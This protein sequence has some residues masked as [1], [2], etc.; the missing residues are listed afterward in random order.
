MR[1]PTATLP[2]LPKSR[3]KEAHLRTFAP[4]WRHARNRISVKRVRDRGQGNRTLPRLCSPTGVQVPPS[5]S[6]ATGAVPSTTPRS[7]QIRIRL[8]ERN[9]STEFLHRG[10]QYPA[11]PAGQLHLGTG[12]GRG[13]DRPARGT[14]VGRG[15][16]ESS[17]SREVLLE[18]VGGGAVV[19]ALIEG[20]AAAAGH[21]E[22][23][24]PSSPAGVLDGGHQLAADP[25]V[26]AR[27]STTSSCS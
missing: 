11:Q 19:Q 26:S 9:P 15:T 17:A 27:S 21:G 7:P 3:F 13:G 24:Y 25:P 18:E 4:V 5:G 16:R 12:S 20:C 8:S 10:A 1:P 2:R 14:S 6:R 22:L 23:P